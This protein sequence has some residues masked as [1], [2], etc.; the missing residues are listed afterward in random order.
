MDERLQAN[1]RAWDEMTAI[2]VGGAYRVEDFKAGKK[3]TQP[4]IP[5]DIGNVAGKSI[6]HLQC[7]FG[8]DSLMWVRQGARV[9]GVDF[10]P[11]AI[12]EAKKLATETGLQAEFIQSDI[13]A[14]PDVL[15][16]QQFDIVLTYYGTITWLPDIRRWGEVV[17]RF[18]KPGGF[19][20]IADTHP[21]A[22]LYEAVRGEERLRLEYPYFTDGKEIRCESEGGTYASPDATRNH[23]VTYQWQHTLASILD[24]LVCRGLKIDYLHE[25]PHTFYDMYY[26]NDASLMTRDENGWWHLKKSDGSLPLMFSLKAT[27]H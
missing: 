24:A 21:I 6:L 20:Y 2:H 8:M 4:N 3:G 17:A 14:L 7:H 5:D 16:G 10:S 13:G 18:L 12:A 1:Q 19:F 25:F 15:G 9:T 26:Y 11:K 22:H 23:R 27:K